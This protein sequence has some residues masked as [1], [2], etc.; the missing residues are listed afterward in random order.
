[1]TPRLFLPLCYS[2]P[3]SKFNDFAVEKQILKGNFA[4]FSTKNQQEGYRY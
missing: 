1:M 2:A 3:Q 4:L